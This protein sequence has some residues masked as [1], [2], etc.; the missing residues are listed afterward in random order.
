MVAVIRRKY[1]GGAAVALGGLLAAACGEPT[2]RYV[3]QPQAGPAGPAGPQGQKG[4]SGAQGAQGAQG[5]A[6]KAAKKPPSGAPSGTEAGP[7]HIAS[8]SPTSAIVEDFKKP[9]PEGTASP[10]FSR[11]ANG[12]AAHGQDQDV[13][14][15]GYATEPLDA[16]AGGGHGALGVKVRLVDLNTALRTNTEW[17]KT[18]QEMIQFL[19]D[20]SSWKGQQVL[21]PMYPDPHGLG[22]NTNILKEEGIPFPKE[23]YT[24][25]DFDE[26]GKAT[27]I[28]DK[29]ALWDMRYSLYW[30]AVVIGPTN[31]AFP[32]DASQAN[33]KVDTPDMLEALEYVYN[34]HTRLGYAQTD[35]GREGKY[36]FNN[37]AK[38][39]NGINPGTVTPPRYPDV[40]PGDGSVIRV[41]H[42][43]HGP[44]NT[45]KQITTPGNVFGCHGVQGGGTKRQSSYRRTWPRGRCARRCSCWSRRPPDTRP[46][47]WRPRRNPAINAAL[48]N[49]PILKQ[50]N[51]LAQYDVPTPASPSMAKILFTIGGEV[52]KRLENGELTPKTAL[53]EA[54]RLTAPLYEEDLQKG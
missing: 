25:A 3:G 47:T 28:P 8:A 35:T 20:G 22:Y 41:T 50:L 44:A 9:A 6:G 17:A 14:S 11:A 10:R 15:G 43:P 2:V 42:Y 48:K 31:A 19:M 34:H 21:M 18:K 38:V 12:R 33:W 52:F 39:T 36:Y 7:E 1:L 51:H 49:N 40:D 4:E 24:W 46:P 37:K 13:P 45:K 30:L 26:I 16:V 29:R 53:E 54:Q 32:R 5:A 27:V 23:G